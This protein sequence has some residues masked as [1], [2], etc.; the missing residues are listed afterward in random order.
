MS[1]AFQD[2]SRFE[3][4]TDLNLYKVAWLD[5]WGGDTSQVWAL[6]TSVWVKIWQLESLW[7]RNN[8]IKF[9]IYLCDSLYQEFFLSNRLREYVPAIIASIM[10]KFQQIQWEFSLG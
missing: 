1:Q 3:R 4:F 9:F 2:I 8:A 10:A 7:Q 6:T 5:F